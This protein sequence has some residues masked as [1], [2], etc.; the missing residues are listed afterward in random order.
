[1]LEA[2]NAKIVTIAGTETVRITEL[3][4]M[5]L[6][7]SNHVKKGAAIKNPF[8]YGMEKLLNESH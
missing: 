2:I 8:G 7:I 6:S 1:M 4:T 5:Q 3:A